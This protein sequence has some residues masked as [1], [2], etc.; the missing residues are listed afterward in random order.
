MADQQFPNK[1]TLTIFIGAEHFANDTFR[2]FCRFSSQILLFSSAAGKFAAINWNLFWPE[3]H[4]WPVNSIIIILFHE[5]KDVM[6]LHEKR[7][8]AAA[9]RFGIDSSS[10]NWSSK[11]LLLAVSSS[12]LSVL[13]ISSCTSPIVTLLALEVQMYGCQTVQEIVGAFL[14]EK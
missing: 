10:V 4:D 12:G 11:D 1:L 14:L 6:L 5:E 2:Q 7:S 3:F 8:S 13:I 9:F